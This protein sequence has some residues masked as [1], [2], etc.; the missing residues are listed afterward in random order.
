MNKL[1]KNYINLLVGALSIN[2]IVFLYWF[3]RCRLAD[4]IT[5]NYDYCGGKEG[6]GFAVF[7]LMSVSIFIIFIISIIL[8]VINLKKKN[9]TTY[10]LFSNI[11]FGLGVL[12]FFMSHYIWFAVDYRTLEEFRIFKEQGRVISEQKQKEWF[13]SDGYKRLEEESFIKTC[14]NSK[15]AKLENSN[16]LI[17]IGCE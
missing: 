3:F 6:Y 7:F 12:V 13:S 8:F 5:E 2:I 17:P 10:N 15:K 4:S 11:L 14:E 1:F 9:S 16:V